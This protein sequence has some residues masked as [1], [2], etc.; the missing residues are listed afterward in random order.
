MS[1]ILAGVPVACP[2]GYWHNFIL[3]NSKALKYVL[4]KDFFFNL[5]FL[6]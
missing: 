5:F 3:K 4:S 1:R 2:S 6:K